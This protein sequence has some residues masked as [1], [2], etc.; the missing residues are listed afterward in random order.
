MSETGSD[1]MLPHLAGTLYTTLQWDMC[2]STE[3]KSEP[4]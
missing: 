1:N 3:I 4:T 2:V